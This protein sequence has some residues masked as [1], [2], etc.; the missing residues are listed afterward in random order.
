LSVV[1][2]VKTELRLRNLEKNNLELTSI[3]ANLS[4]DNRRT[5]LRG[6]ETGQWLSVLL[7]T[8]KGTELLAQEFPEMLC[9]FAT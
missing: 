6:K 9:F 7:S 3:A 4:C 8:V 1:R 2:E 5:I